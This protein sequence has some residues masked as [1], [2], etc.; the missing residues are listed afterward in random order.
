[1]LS[2]YF[3]VITGKSTHDKSQSVPL[4]LSGSLSGDETTRIARIKNS[5]KGSDIG[6]TESSIIFRLTFK[7]VAI[8]VGRPAS[9]FYC[10]RDRKGQSSAPTDHVVQ[11]LTNA[12]VLFQSV[13]NP[14]GSGSKTAHMSLED[15]SASVNTEFVRVESTPP[16]LGPFAADFRAV[17]QTEREGSLVSQDFSFDC[18]SIKCCMAPQDIRVVLSVTR[19]VAE[20]LQLLQTSTQQQHP[21][22]HSTQIQSFVPALMHFKKKGSG[23][24]TRIRAELHSFSF[25]LMHAFQSM[26]G[27]RPFIDFNARQFKGRLE[28]CLAALSGELS[29][30]LS[31]NFFN[32]VVTSWENAIEPFRVVA[33]IDQMPNEL[34]V[35]IASPDMIN[36]NITGIV[37]SEIV[38]LQH[39]R[40]KASTD[41]GYEPQNFMSSSRVPT[42]D[43][44]FVNLTGIDLSISDGCAQMMEYD[45]KNRQV[46]VPQGSS[47]SLN[48]W[49][50]GLD[51]IAACTLTLSASQR[52]TIYNLPLAPSATSE[53]RIF[54]HKWRPRII[55]FKGSME[56]KA[57]G[58]ECCF[59]PVN[60]FVMQ[61]QRIR[62]SVIDMY[63]IERGQDLL[64]STSWSPESSFSS[65]NTSAEIHSSLNSKSLWR[66]PYLEGDA[67]EW[68]DM[69][70]LLQSSKDSFTLPDSNWTWVNDWEIEIDG[71]LG[72]G[73][74]AD[75]WE[76]ESDFETFSSLRRFYQ[77]GDSCRRRRWTRTR[78]MKPLPINDPKRIL[79]IVWEVGKEENGNIL[80]KAR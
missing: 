65:G 20:R 66:S 67:H 18:E 10:P 76:Y 36:V 52:Q 26:P 38:N 12:S 9:D 17:Y 79:S 33:A 73:T 54:S 74:D 62:P 37:L 44:D 2:F 39:T 7:S 29:T 41:V 46:L 57:Y 70:C 31:L 71:D 23:I 1:M 24:A 43:I 72:V 56:S 49:F 68:T 48:S 35:A 64:C 58:G 47:I 63:S 53:R 34:V 28:G 21:H 8:L 25:V 13:E 59:E 69:T 19:K 22:Q 14:D 77:R 11:I 51:D 27:I 16:I 78:I 15:F 61:N 45:Q 3:H 30:C 42:R 5:S 55:D 32:P 4:A 6:P 80:V 40:K 60:E 75:G 50:I